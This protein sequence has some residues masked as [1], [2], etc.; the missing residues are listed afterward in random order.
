MPIVPFSFRHCQ[1]ANIHVR[2]FN[3]VEEIALNAPSSGCGIQLTLPYAMLQHL[4]LQLDTQ[5]SSQAV[6]AGRQEQIGMSRCPKPMNGDLGRDGRQGAKE[7]ALIFFFGKKSDLSFSVHSCQNGITNHLEMV[8]LQMSYS[9]GAY[10][11]QSRKHIFL[12]LPGD[13]K[14]QMGTECKAIYGEDTSRCIM[15]IGKTMVTIEKFQALLVDTLQAY[16]KEALFAGVYHQSG[17]RLEKF[18]CNKVGASGK[19]QANAVG[20]CQQPLKYGQQVL[21]GQ[22]STGFLLQIGKVL[23]KSA[24]EQLLFPLSQLFHYTVC[25]LQVGGGETGRS[26]KD[27]PSVQSVGARQLEIKG[28]LP[29]P[30]AK[31]LPIMITEGTY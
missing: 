2:L 11:L 13:T 8:K 14:N 22:S 4:F 20:K 9:Q 10:S 21:D 26:T 16:L 27:T 7:K 5:I 29:N 3:Y 15:K 18:V 25:G 19:D 30:V 23:F 1:A 24:M 17:Q 28:N 12:A 6:P 31:F